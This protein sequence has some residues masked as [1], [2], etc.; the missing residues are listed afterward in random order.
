MVVAQAAWVGL[1]AAPF[2]LPSPQTIARLEIPFC[3]SL[4]CAWSDQV[5]PPSW[6]T[7]TDALG[8]NARDDEPM[9]SGTK[10]MLEADR[11]AKSSDFVIAEF[12]HLVALGTVKVVVRRV[13]VVVLVCASVGEPELAK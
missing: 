9:A 2:R 10:A 3:K 11:L 13:A 4:R 8:T 5:E 7:R 6:A 12:D 1:S